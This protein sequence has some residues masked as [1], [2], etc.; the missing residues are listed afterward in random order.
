MDR[1]VE[2]SCVYDCEAIQGWCIEYTA[3]GPQPL[4]NATAATMQRGG[5]AGKMV[6]I[7][8]H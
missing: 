7:G 4:S 1:D 5:A 3:T 6:D 2:V 8:W